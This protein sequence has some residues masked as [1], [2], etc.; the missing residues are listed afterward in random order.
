MDTFPSCFTIIFPLLFFDLY[1]FFIN[2]LR[3]KKV[4]IYDFHGLSIET[5]YFQYLTIIVIIV[6]FVNKFIH[7][8]MEKTQFHCTYIH[9]Q[10][11]PW[12]SLFLT[13]LYR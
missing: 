9:D 6:V 13:S 3:W 11:S 8:F 12:L 2:G 7:S 4:L 1:E 10:F 5:V